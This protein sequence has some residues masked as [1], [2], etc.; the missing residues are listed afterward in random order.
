LILFGDR[1]K[2]ANIDLDDVR[3]I[4]GSKIDDTYDTLRK[5]RFGS[6]KGLHIDSYK[7]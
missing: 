7:K 3:R 2:K 5:Y 4:N 1:A 6:P